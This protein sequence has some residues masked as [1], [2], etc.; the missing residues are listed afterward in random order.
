MTEKDD[1]R[2]ELIYMAKLSE[3]TERFDEMVDYMKKVIE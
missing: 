2:D 3:Q 1:N